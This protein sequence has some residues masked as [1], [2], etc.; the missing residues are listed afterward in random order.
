MYKKNQASMEFLMTYVWGLLVVLI[1][2]VVMIYF[3][4]LKPD[5]Y[6]PEKAEFSTPGIVAKDFSATENCVELMV[7]NGLGKQI[8]DFKVNLTD[9]NNGESGSS[10]G[11]NIAPGE[12]E[13]IPIGAVTTDK[14]SI[15]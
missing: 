13:H 12:A 2:I 9:A 5:N 6:L 7:Y 14:G 8:Y 15:S 4:L 3:G 11:V 1:I 10:S